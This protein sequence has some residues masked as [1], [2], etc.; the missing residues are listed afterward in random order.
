MTSGLVR[1]YPLIM[2]HWNWIR[3]SMPMS[4]LSSTTKPFKIVPAPFLKLNKKDLWK[5][6]NE[7]RN[8]SIYKVIVVKSSDWWNICTDW[9][10]FLSQFDESQQT[11]IIC[12]F[13]DNDS[14]FSEKPILPVISKWR[15]AATRD[16]LQKVTSPL[17]SCSSISERPIL[18]TT[19]HMYKGISP[20]LWKLEMC[21]HWDPLE[22][23][24]RQD[25]HWKEKKLGALWRGDL[26]GKHIPAD[27]MT[28]EQVCFANQRCRF[29]FQHR[30]SHLVNAGLSDGL[31]WLKIWKYK[32]C[33][34]D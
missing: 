22:F 34:R 1:I 6:K 5:Q 16:N 19:V 21:R 14:A 28:D 8:A 25:F 23:A 31:N 9:T 7:S 12:Q 13:G 20:I 2:T 27:E 24:R 15:A 30:N 17:S 29:V 4:N 18:N 11:P 26:T 32:W 10:C 33:S 3:L